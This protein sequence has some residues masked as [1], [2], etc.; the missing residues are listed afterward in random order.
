MRRTESAEDSRMLSHESYFRVLTE[1][2]SGS[3]VLDSGDFRQD[4]ERP[5]QH[6]DNPDDGAKAIVRRNDLWQEV[7]ADARGHPKKHYPDCHEEPAVAFLQ[8]LKKTAV[9]EHHARGHREG[10]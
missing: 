8:L 1:Q 3:F 7:A 10:D 5:P 9:P 6:A 2:I 4:E